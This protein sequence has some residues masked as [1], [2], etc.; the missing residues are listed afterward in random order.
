MNVTLGFDPGTTKGTA[1]AGFASKLLF[2]GGWWGDTS[3]QFSQLPPTRA[4]IERPRIYPGEKQK[5]DANDL[6]DL[7]LAAGE[8]CG[9]LY[10]RGVASVEYVEP[11]TWKG[12]HPKPISHRMIWQ[13]LYTAERDVF[14]SYAGM[15]VT[16]IETKI[17]DACHRLAVTGKVTAYSWKANDLLDAVGIGLHAIGRL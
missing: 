5:G 11:R 17:E 10:W 2:C 14:A 12:Q 13:R 4:V 3:L 15:T 16:A 8:L 1:F 9:S 6:I 7:A